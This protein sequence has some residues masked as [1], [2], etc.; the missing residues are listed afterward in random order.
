MQSGDDVPGSGNGGTLTLVAHHLKDQ[1]FQNAVGPR[2]QAFKHQVDIGCDLLT[3]RAD[4]GHFEVELKLRAQSKEG[5]AL[6]FS[7]ELTYAG[8]F[9][10]QNIPED[11]VQAALLV[12]APTLLFSYARDIMAETLQKSGMPA[13]KLAAMDFAALYRADTGTE[14]SGNIAVAT[15]VAAQPAVQPE[16][17]QLFAT[18]IYA[19]PLGVSL[20]A[21]LEAA[22]LKL[23]QEDEAGRIWSKMGLRGGYTSFASI[24]DLPRRDPAFAALVENL[25]RHVAA[26]VRAVEFDMQGRR[27][28]LDSIWVNVLQE[29][30]SHP[31]HIHQHSALSG[32]YYVSVPPGG[33]AIH[34]EDP[35]MGLMM[36]APPRSQTARPENRD[37]ISMRPKAGN[38]FLWESWLRHGVEP[39]D[40]KSPRISISFNYK[41]EAIAKNALG[42]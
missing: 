16:I 7:M 20:H 9:R 15:A 3:R 24:L 14:P 40:D 32:T 10:L 37:F 26:F 8:L 13:L 34:F 1:S 6:V 35:R 21:E 27:L 30:A 17:H 4:A 31:A 11:A 28:V 33:A 12:Q 38:L 36:A 41:A 2:G 19:A 42:N 25:D 39:H 22:C 23:A 5:G 29:S 18:S